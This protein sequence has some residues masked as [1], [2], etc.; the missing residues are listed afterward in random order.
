M[1]PGRASPH[2][3]GKPDGAI[4]ER[5]TITPLRSFP[6]P[7]STHVCLWLLRSHPWLERNPPLASLDLW[8]QQVEDA[9]SL[10]YCES[11]ELSSRKGV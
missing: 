10:S 2:P 11:G 4:W 1:G 9:G 6:S 8:L 5:S 3:H 7:L